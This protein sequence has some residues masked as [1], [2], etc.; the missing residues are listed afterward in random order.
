MRIISILFSV[1]ML[2]AS[3]SHAQNIIN[4]IQSDQVQ[5]VQTVDGLVRRLTGN[6]HLITKDA[7]IRADSAYHYVDK[8]EI[9]GFGNITIVTSSETIQSD[10]IRYDVSN[11]ISSLKGQIVIQTKTTSIYSSSALYSF[12]TEIALFNDPIWLK[13]STAVMQ[14]IS[15]I[16]FNQT[17]SVALFG[18]V[19]LSDSTQYI[20]ADSLF[21][22]RAA[23][24]Y[25]LF[26]NVLIQD[27]ENRTEIQGNYVFADSTG[28]RIISDN[29]RLRRISGEANDTTWLSAANI[30]VTKIDS[31][32]I[33]D[34]TGDVISI[35]KNNSAR[36]D[37][38]RYDEFSGMFNLRSTPIVWYK[39]IQ[40]SGDTI[41]IFTVDD[42]LESL[43]AV[44]NAFSV[45][46]D[47]VSFRFNQMKGDSIF[48]SFEKDQVNQIQTRGN[49][50]LFLNYTDS[51]ENPD[52]AV[53]ISSKEL[54]IYFDNSEVTDVTA[55]SKIDGETLDESMEL[56]DFRLDGFKWN[57][58]IRPVWPDFTFESRFNPVSTKPPFTRPIPV[59]TG[60]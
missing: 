43:H 38:L 31:L 16:Y 14:A 44:G 7:E 45:Q 18:N 19:Q 53:S 49:A 4:I 6:V 24:L 59:K 37:T 17:D 29:A 1:F 23:N 8:N 28:K 57:P 40:L 39:N 12:L 33:I 56:S 27:F 52:G 46:K 32:N 9:E 3:V 5:A 41:D 20:E 47:S 15:G 58:E 51:D 13:D 10:Y 36:S 55:L 11:E 35:Q 42:T 22:S 34:A 21:A 25:E 26:G 48:V 30:E 54:I 60:K 2:L 50:E